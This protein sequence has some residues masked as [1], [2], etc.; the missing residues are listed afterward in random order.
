MLYEIDAWSECRGLHFQV[1]PYPVVKVLDGPLFPAWHQYGIL[2]GFMRDTT[3]H[4]NFLFLT[5]SWTL[6]SCRVCMVAR[7]QESANTML[8]YMWLLIHVIYE[9]GVV[10]DVA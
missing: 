10:L 3:L 6:L 4:H 5:H 9:Y 2:Q 1:L 8:F 7:Q